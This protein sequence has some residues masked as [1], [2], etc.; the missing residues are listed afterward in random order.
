MTSTRW[1]SIAN[2]A[3]LFPVLLVGCGGSDRPS[4]APASGVVRL[5]G[6][7]VEGATVTFIPVGGGRPASGRTDSNGRYTIKTYH[8]APGAIVGDH[9]VGVV[10]M[11]GPGLYAIQGDAPATAQSSSEEDDGSDSLSEI[12]VVDS[13]EAPE[14]E[15]VYDVPQQYM[16]ANESGLVVTVPSEGSD[17]LDLQLT[18]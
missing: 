10:K 7:P 14:P 18:R 5:D 8:D 2:L 9:K 12:A 3:L 6:E 11:S 15:I 16:N 13:G 4:L 1:L 17:K